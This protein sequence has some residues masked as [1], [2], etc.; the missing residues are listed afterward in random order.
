[1]NVIK[2]NGDIEEVS[3]DK[4]LNRIKMISNGLKVDYIDIAQKVIGRIYDKVSTSELDELAAHLC[5]SMIVDNPD[6]G[7]LAARIIISNHQKNTSPSFSETVYILYN[8]KDINGI[9]NPLV[10]DLLYETVMK[11]KEKINNFIDYNRDYTFD[12]FGFKTLERSYLMKINKKVIER[13]QHMFMRVALGIHGKDLKDALQTYDL[14]S[15][16]MFTHAT[17]TLFNSGTPMPQL[18]SCFLLSI[19]S[20][21]IDGIFDSIHESAKISKYSGG[22]GLN[23]HDVR[24]KGSH[25]R[26]TNGKSDGIAPMLK[27]FNHTA[28]Y[29][30]QCFTPETI[31]YTKEGIKRMDEIT[32]EDYLLTKDTTYRKVNEISKNTVNKQIIKLRGKYSFETVN[33]TDEH[34]IYVIQGQKKMTNFNTIQKRLKENIIKP[35][36]IL[37]KDLTED[38]ML[39]YPIPSYENDVLDYDNDYCRFYGI[40]IG[41]GHISKSTKNNSTAVEYG[42][43]LNLDSKMDTVEF[44]KKYLGDRNIHYWITKSEE[45]KSY[46]IKWSNQIINI[47]YDYLYDKNHEKYIH[48]S[49]IHLPKEKN[50]S[51][52][53][54]LIETDGGK[55]HEIQFYNSSYQVVMTVRYLLL[56]AGVISSGCIKDNTRPSGKQD[57]IET[58]KLSYALRIPKDKKLTYI[59]GDDY[60]YSPFLGYF[61]YENI[62][63]S[64]IRDINKIDYN[65]EVYDFNMT[66]NH[67]YTIAS[68]GLVHNS[69]RRAGSIAVY[70]EPWH[71]DFF[72]FLELKKP[73]G[74]EEDRARD[75]FYAMWIPDLFMER[76]KNNGQWSLMCPDQ[77]RG[78]CDCYGDEFNKLYE[79]YESEGKY[80]KQIDAQSLWFK[81]LESQIE[82]G[83]PY[84]LSK[85]ACNKKSNQQNLGT[86]KSSNLC[87]APETNILTDKGYYMISTLVEEEVNVWNGKEFSKTIIKQTGKMQKLITVSFDN[88]KTL[89]CTEYHKFYI[90]DNSIKEAKDLLVGDILKTYYL[91][92]DNTI[93]IV[94]VINII[95]NNRYD[96]TYCFNEPLEHS[97]IFNGILTGQC[98]EIVEYSSPDETAVC[99][100]ASICL[101][102]FIEKDEESQKNLFNFE[103]LHEITMVITKN[104]NKVIDINFYPVEKARRSNLRHRP[105]GIGVQGLADTFIMMRFPF[106]SV[107]AA[108]L[109]RDIFETIYHASVEQSMKISKTRFEVL[110][111]GSDEYKL[112]M[113]EFEP[114]VNSK[115][116]GAYSTFDGSP[117]SQGLL[118]FDMWNVKPSNKYDWESLKTE[119]MKYGMRNSLLVA[120]MPTASTSQIMSFNECFEPITSN[121]YKRKTMAGEFILVNKYLVKDLID[122]NLWNKDLKNKIIIDD[123]SIQNIQGIPDDI[124]ALYKTVWEIKQK[125]LI[126]QAVDRGAFVDQSMSM[127]LFMADP[128]FQKLSSMHF[129]SWSKGLKTLIYYLRSKPKAKQQQFTIE[130]TAPKSRNIVCTDEV[131]TVCSS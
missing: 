25:I 115:Y 16:K 88:G 31:V 91:P 92:D 66:D 59:F 32:T 14:M 80:T 117:A 112:N 70:L 125:V 9:H 84:L 93:Y 94:K 50:L 69:G 110:S 51:L 103:K 44:V 11:N 87:V 90:N 86:I 75:L 82:T 55:T 131:C 18:S 123:G 78:L 21:S 38:D 49:F 29:V 39:G 13:P 54:G 108:N 19:N 74:N 28:R 5:S 77:C 6:Y 65:G 37:A 124:K 73:H 81:I 47:S 7:T 42:I 12:Y 60:K 10:S 62:I 122:L 26:G 121:I 99:N 4:V 33:V 116:P 102:S 129:Y 3:F 104:L 1:M 76:V 72:E 119:I 106:D 15:R 120:P 126:D 85:D 57:Y 58:K 27:V 68:L 127:N 2:R 83:V 35:K 107:E 22:I 113:N 118:Q 114:A 101:P 23:I 67:N 46:A 8:N 71:A 41:D 56:R 111:N 20:D 98:C 61:T 100:L 24:A 109:N 48:N 64:R 105:I 53:Q 40:M 52:L 89:D 43:T 36:F 45:N 128:D 96:D 30:N 95:D 79:K 130:A 63:W 34:E 17:P 97:G